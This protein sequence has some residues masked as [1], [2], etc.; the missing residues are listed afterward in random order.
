MAETSRLVSVDSFPGLYLTGEINTIQARFQVLI[1]THIASSDAKHMAEVESK[2]TELDTLFKQR[3]KEYEAT[4]QIQND[5]DMFMKAAAAYD[6]I[7]TDWV[8]VREYSRKSQNVKA[9]DM[10]RSQLEP[11][12]AELNG[13]VND[14][15]EF[16]HDQGNQYAATA[17]KTA[18]SAR[19]WIWS[20][21]MT[22]MLAGGVLA[23]LFVRSITAVLKQVV[24]QLS[25]GSEH[26]A[27]A[28]GEIASA[29]QAMAQST[30]EQSASLEQTSASAEQ[31]SSMTQRN[32]DN[33]KQSASLVALVDRSVGE[34]NRTLEEMVGSMKEIGESSSKISRIIK[35]I[36]EIAFQ[37]NILA[38]NAAVEAA[39]AGEAGMGFSV[40]A[41]EVRN[42]AQRSAQAAKDTAS[43]IEESIVR[44][45]EGSAKLDRVAASIL[46]ITES[47]NKV[48]VLVDEVNLGSQEQA[49]GVSQIAKNILA[50]QST[51]QRSAAQAEESAAAGE[52]LAS[53]AESMKESVRHLS[54]LVIAS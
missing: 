12:F 34:A 29:A 44:S 15:I 38:L 45:G 30:S 28:A 23:F 42:L 26:V 16:N 2:L 50:M 31:M 52:E 54:G 11:K 4:I 10:F 49:G 7:V 3:M 32:A 14:L 6:S 27:A 43:L 33:S 9:F 20:L 48:R 21:L 24:T 1:L 22:S 8:K 17:A 39:R 46:S 40:V 13:G 36:D 18:Q 53:Q 41:D 25:E 35:V 19:V 5:R 51:T 47:A 37:T